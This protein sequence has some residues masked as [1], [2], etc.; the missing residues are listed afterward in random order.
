M[1]KVST[2]TSDTRAT[3]GF[4]WISGS[5]DYSRKQIH[6]GIHRY[7]VHR[8]FQCIPKCCFQC[9]LNQ[10]SLVAGEPDHLSQS[11]GDQAPDLNVHEPICHNGEVPHHVETPYGI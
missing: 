8:I 6:F 7:Y 5:K 1:F 10:E 11:I 4:C 9:C 2:I 3:P